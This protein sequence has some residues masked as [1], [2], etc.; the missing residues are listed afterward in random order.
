M[1]V[2]IMTVNELLRW[3]HEETLM[4]DGL[5]RMLNDMPADLYQPMKAQMQAHR[6][7]SRWLDQQ[8]AY[9]LD[10]TDE[11]KAGRE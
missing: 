2:L 4:A 10:R 3:A 6:N 8:V 9:H 1:T 11:E 5:E 7:R